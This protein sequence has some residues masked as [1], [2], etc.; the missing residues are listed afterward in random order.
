MQKYVISRKSIQEKKNEENL[1]YVC[2]ME[3]G[4]SNSTLKYFQTYKCGLS[5]TGK[6][7]TSS[8]DYGDDDSWVHE[9]DICKHYSL[10]SVSCVLGKC[11]ASYGMLM[12]YYN[13]HEKDGSKNTAGD[14]FLFRMNKVL[15]DLGKANIKLL[16]VGYNTPNEQYVRGRGDGGAL[17]TQVNC[18]LK[19]FATRV[20]SA[21]KDTFQNKYNKCEFVLVLDSEKKGNMPPIVSRKFGKDLF[22]SCCDH[23]NKSF[24]FGIPC[25][26]RSEEAS[27]FW[28][29]TKEKDIIFRTDTDNSN[30]S[31][32]TGAINMMGVEILRLRKCFFIYQRKSK[33]KKD[34]LSPIGTICSH[35]NT[36]QKQC[37]E[38]NHIGDFFEG[39]IGSDLGIY[40]DNKSSGGDDTE[41]VGE[42]LLVNEKDQ[43]YFLG[44]K[45]DRVYEKFAECNIILCGRTDRGN[46]TSNEQANRIGF[47]SDFR[48]EDKMYDENGIDIPDRICPE[49]TKLNED[50]LLDYLK[51]VPL[52]GY[53]IKEKNC[54]EDFCVKHYKMCV[55]E[56]VLED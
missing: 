44:A 50:R 28:N 33:I 31:Q 16:I 9:G 27:E 25:V 18:Y 10:H 42:M 2:W 17:A 3:G 45:D 11:R 30:L 19:Y 5:T 13:K 43:D 54:E 26:K 21:D 46:D 36:L 35:L 32:S 20:I 53:R 8:L 49:W 14:D 7:V 6:K 15:R 37:T 24:G 55:L 34:G 4:G 29:R 39:E 12:F 48:Q 56:V 22:S 23:F 51:G 47:L 40:V 41:G 52:S 38:F 1:M